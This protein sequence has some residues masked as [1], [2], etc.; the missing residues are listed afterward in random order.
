M[1]KP[2]GRFKVK[3]MTGQGRVTKKQTV[4]SRTF[5][6][7]ANPRAVKAVCTAKSAKNRG[8]QVLAENSIGASE[9]DTVSVTAST[10]SVLFS[11]FILYILPVIFVYC[12]AYPRRCGV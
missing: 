11:S 8:V 5:Y 6:A 7:C 1:Q 12:I 2:A 9:G 4:N 3:N 10:K